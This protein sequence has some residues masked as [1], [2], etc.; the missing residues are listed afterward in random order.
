[1]KIC[2]L[3]FGT[4]LIWDASPG[5][6]LYGSQ[7]GKP[8]IYPITIGGRHHTE[9]WVLVIAPGGS[10]QYIGESEYIR[11]PTEQEFKSFTWPESKI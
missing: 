3:A 8:I 2:N 7:M 11:E 5:T 4:K 10:A 6:Y 1:M 9:K